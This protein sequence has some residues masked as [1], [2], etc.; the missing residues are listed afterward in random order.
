[1]NIRLLII[2]GAEIKSLEIH[3]LTAK[4]LHAAEDPIM[5]LFF[6]F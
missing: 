5:K 2:D 1:M 6:E 3:D 4:R